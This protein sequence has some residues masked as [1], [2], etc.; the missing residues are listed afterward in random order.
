MPSK[1][2]E[3]CATCKHAKNVVIESVYPPSP[4]DIRLMCWI[5]DVPVHRPGVN[6]CFVNPWNFCDKWEPKEVER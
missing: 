3:R 1:V 4:A 5:N 2:G 6:E